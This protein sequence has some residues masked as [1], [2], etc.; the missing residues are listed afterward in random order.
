MQNSSPINSLV[1]TVENDETH[2]DIVSIAQAEVIDP[3]YL[4]SCDSVM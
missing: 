3:A 1:M 2:D 4:T